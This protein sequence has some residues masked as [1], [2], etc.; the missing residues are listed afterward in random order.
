MPLLTKL[1]WWARPRTCNW[2]SLLRWVFVTLTSLVVRLSWPLIRCNLQ[3]LEAE[4]RLRMRAHLRLERAASSKMLS[5]IATSLRQ[6]WPRR[7]GRIWLGICRGTWS[8]LDA[9]WQVDITW[10]RFS[11]GS[12]RVIRVRCQ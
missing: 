11:I 2:D 8:L 7:S 9:R 1:C 10:A 3:A 5:Q 4:T 6:V 12:S